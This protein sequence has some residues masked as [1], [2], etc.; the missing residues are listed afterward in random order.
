MAAPRINNAIKS[1]GLVRSPIPSGAGI[2]NI[3]P[4]TGLSTDYLNHFTEAIMA[5]EMAGEMPECLDD[6]RDWRP[7]SYIEHFAASRFSNRAAV[8]R[9]YEAAD[10]ALR[11]ALDVASRA[12]NAT[13]WA[14]RNAAIRGRSTNGRMRH[15]LD[16]LRP[17]ISR[18]A[19][20]INGTVGTDRG[21]T[22]ATI[23]AMFV[24]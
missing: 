16:E 14:A 15:S 17:L 7:K 2:P 8:V 20:L 24:R 1:A 23:D 6:L 22:Q 12:L 10:P 19:A 9:A 13:L 4:I 18:M 5:L 11:A 3:N 21:A